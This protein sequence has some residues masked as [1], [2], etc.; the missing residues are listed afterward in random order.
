MAQDFTTTAL[1]SSLKRRGMLPS[2]TDTLSTT[3]FLA[4]ATEELQTYVFKV[5]LAVRE[6]YAV[7][8]YDQAL[9]A[10]TSAYKLPSRAVGGKLR[11]AQLY[12]SA[13]GSYTQLV[14]LEPE[15]VTDILD[16]GNVS[17]FYLQGDDIVFMPV[18][19]SAVTVRLTYFRRPSALVATSA[20][21]TSTTI[22]SATMTIS[23]TPAAFTASQT[24]DIVRAKPPFSILAQDLSASS[25]AGNVVT[26]T[27]PAGVTSIVTSYGVAAG[28]YVCLA[29]ESPVAQI[30]VELHPL[31]SQRTVYKCLEALGDD[32]SQM[33]EAAADK[34]RQDALT[35]LTPRVEGT[36]RPIVNRFGPG[37]RR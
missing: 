29:G 24:Y 26:F 30:P 15:H 27:L 11:N 9:S 33:A 12:D 19:S 4:I 25:V 21:G 31:L 32:K 6:E 13:S 5:L 20:V 36:A 37:F 34:M 28:D 1:L 35:L 3:D 23:S 2:N 8:F 10:G 18:P 7:A 17:A 14:R 16:R 22:G